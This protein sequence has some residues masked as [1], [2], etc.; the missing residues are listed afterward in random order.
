M[1]FNVLVA[2]AHY[3]FSDKIKSE[4]AWSFALVKYLGPQV[5][6][7]DVLTGVN[8]STT[9]LS[10]NTKIYPLFSTRST[11]LVVEFIHH[12][13]FYPLV[14]LRALIL[15]SKKKYLIIHHML[16]LSYATVNPLVFLSKIFFPKVK[17]IL[18]PLQL[19]QMQSDEQDLNVVFLGKQDYSFVSK[20]IYKL[21]MFITFLVKPIARIMYESADLVVCNSQTSQKYYSSIFPKAKFSVIYTGMDKTKVDLGAKKSNHKIRILCVGLFSKRKGQIILLQAMKELVKKY[22][23]I[24]LTLIGGGDQDSIYRQ[25]VFENKLDKYVKFTGQVSY[26]ELLLAYQ[27]HDIFCLPTLSDTSPYVILEAMT[28]GLPIVAT[29]VGSIKEM[30]NKA[31]IIVKPADA[32]SLELAL[33]NIIDDSSLRNQMSKFGVERIRKNFTW[34]TISKQWLDTYDKLLK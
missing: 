21:T 5:K 23:N 29:D 26:A 24:E 9:I 20:I 12:V 15:M 33:G 28:Y 6:S 10:R 16:P 22:K 2:P 18:G 11:S 17:I 25:F 3:L 4:P 8:D 30:V 32:S 14:T 31:G 19:P 27:N 34:D 1:K 13:V 7:L